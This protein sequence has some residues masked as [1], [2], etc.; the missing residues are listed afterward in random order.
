MHAFD[1]RQVR[2][3]LGAAVAGVM[4]GCSWGLWQEREKGQLLDQRTQLQ[5][6][7]NVL[8]EQQARLAIAQENARLQS[9]WT[10]RAHSW[11]I[12]RQHLRSE[13]HTSELQSQR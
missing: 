8:R 13:E 11:Q 3:V 1:P 6:Q 10:E 12:Q 5:A 7:A 4:L 2:L 9:Q